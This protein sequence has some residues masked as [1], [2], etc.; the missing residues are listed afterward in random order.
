MRRNLVAMRFSLRSVGRDTSYVLIAFPRSVIAFVLSVAGL[1]AGLGTAVLGVVGVIFIFATLSLARFFADVE[2]RALPEVL[3]ARLPRPWYRPVKPTANWFQK[4]W[5]PVTQLQSWLDLLHAIVIFPFS[6]AAFAVAVA[7]WA[8]ALYG[9]FYP[10][11]GWILHRLPD[12]TDL[13]ELIG[14]GTGLGVRIL[15]H[16]TIGVVAAATLPIVLR[17]VTIIRAG[18]SRT[19]LTGLAEYRL[20]FDGPGEA[21]EAEAAALRRLE[22][23]GSDGP[24]QRLASLAMELTQVRRQLPHD[25]QAADARLAR[26]ITQT[27]ETLDVLRTMSREAAPAI[28]A[29]RG[30]T[31]ALAALASRAPLSVELDITADQRYPTEVENVIYL[32]VSEALANIAKHSEATQATVSLRDDEGTLLLLVADNGKGGAEAAKGQGL[33]ALADRLRAVGA[34]LTVQSP[35][36]GPTVIGAQIPYL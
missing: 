25:P 9:L 10:L 20:R 1:S 12:F 29:E 8:V 23:D 11:F 24:Q 22:G 15:F 7:W 4:L 2:R 26:A 5:H 18:I 31:P 16:L 32:V 30:L 19:L 6:V 14:I 21:H 17:G 3:G 13:P 33:A 35:E 28:L 36:G 34:D 27:Q